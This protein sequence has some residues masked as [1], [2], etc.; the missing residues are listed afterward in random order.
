MQIAGVL[1]TMRRLAH[2][3]NAFT[4][5]PAAPAVSVAGAVAA[6]VGNAY[7]SRTTTTVKASKAA[8]STAPEE[9]AERPQGLVVGS[10][11]AMQV[12]LSS[13]AP[14]VSA[15]RAS[16]KP[17]EQGLQELRA[18]ERMYELSTPNDRVLAY[19]NGLYQ[20]LLNDYR[21]LNAD[22]RP[23]KDAIRNDPVAVRATELLL[24]I[25]ANH[26]DMVEQLQSEG[27]H[28]SKPLGQPVE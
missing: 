24:D 25:G 3:A 5:V 12:M 15:F 2:N 17:E 11:E 8:R 18:I 20:D 26:Y 1:E 10:P 28:P 4:I 14:P 7:V 19:E 27:H 22:G 6:G 9:Q 16:G 13:E 21:P 23:A